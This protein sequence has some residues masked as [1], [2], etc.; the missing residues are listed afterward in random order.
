[1]NPHAH[2]IKEWLYQHRWSEPVTH[3]LALHIIRMSGDN[4]ACN[5]DAISAI[6][7]LVRTGDLWLCDEPASMRWPYKIN[8]ARLSRSGRGMS[9]C[10][11]CGKSLWA[12]ETVDQHAKRMCE[13][14]PEPLSDA[15]VT[16][17]MGDII[18]MPY[19][20]AK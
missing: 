20:R 13:P 7:A 5:V 2:I 8:P 9:R 15:L 11:H 12:E 16:D 19:V 18:P 6:D 1:M 3:H 4:N 10:K 14:I 17:E